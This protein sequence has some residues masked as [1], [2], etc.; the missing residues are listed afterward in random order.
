[1][2]NIGQVRKSCLAY[3]PE[4]E[5]RSYYYDLLASRHLY[6]SFVFDIFTSLISLLFADGNFGQTNARHF[7]YFL[8]ASADGHQYSIR[9]PRLVSWVSPKRLDLKAVNTTS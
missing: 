1:V 5:I 6:V 7:F 3:F 4:A 8:N 2:S 9:R